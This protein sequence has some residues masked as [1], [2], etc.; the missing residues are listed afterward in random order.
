MIDS[1][2][3]YELLKRMTNNISSN[4]MWIQKRSYL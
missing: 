1:K 2:Q 3:Y 4:F